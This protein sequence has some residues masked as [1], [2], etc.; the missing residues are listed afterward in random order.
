M[1]YKTTIEVVTDADNAHDATDIAGEFLRGDMNAGADL[2]VKTVSVAKSR[3]VKAVLVT[4]AAAAVLGT[5]LIGGKAYITV[6]KAQKTP[7]TAYAIQ[8]PLRTNQA[9]LQSEEF[10]QLWD[11]EQKSR[12]DSQVR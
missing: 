6:A 11:K 12:V 1:H 4:G 5:A 7:V 10:K 3:V 2:R 8:P 9:D